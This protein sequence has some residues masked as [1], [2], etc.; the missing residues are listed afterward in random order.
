MKKINNKGYMLVEII[1][2]FSITFAI[3]FFL[4]ELVIKFKNKNDDLLVETQVKTDQTIITNRLMEYVTT[5]EKFKKV[6]KNAA[7]Q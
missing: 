5:E 6:N 7:L 1:L 2:A 3:I 4:M